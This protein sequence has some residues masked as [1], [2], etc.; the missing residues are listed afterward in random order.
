MFAIFF[1][2]DQVKQCV[3][4]SDEFG[5]GQCS[6]EEFFCSPNFDGNLKGKCFPENVVRLRCESDDSNHLLT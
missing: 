6:A 3:N 2:C 4:G 5:C 1:Q